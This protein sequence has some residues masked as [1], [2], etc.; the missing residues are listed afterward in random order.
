MD[1]EKN[2]QLAERP[3]Y[4]DLTPR[5]LQEAMDFCDM[6]AKSDMVPKGFVG[7]PGNIMVAVQWGAEIGL[8]PMQAMQ[9][10]AVINGRPS[11]WGDAMLALVI[12]SP[13]CK[14]V[15]ET[16]EG[17]GDDYR[18]VCVAQR[19][20]KQDKIATFSVSDAKKA[21]LLGKS[22]PWTQFRDRMLKLRARGFA[23]R[24]QFPDV[25]KGMD[26]AEVIVDH[27]PIHT[28]PAALGHAAAAKPADPADVERKQ[29]VAD[30]EAEAQKGLADFKAKWEA[31][32]KAQR[33]MVGTIERDRIKAL[34]KPAAKAE[35]AK[36]APVDESQQAPAQDAPKPTYAELMDRVNK[37]FGPADLT[38]VLRDCGHLPADQQREIEA[39]VQKAQED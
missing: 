37:A 35:E 21:G 23:L 3:A 10:I 34:C 19:H 6:L 27:E 1:H 5:T 7:A 28:G 31:L 2:T 16:Y 20:G 33:T 9:N 25:L 22:G 11:L 39:A 17:A 24:D 14:D 29:L 13:V 32:T 36:D 4:A 8:K 18:A 38:A 26:I 15:V 12:S 30:L